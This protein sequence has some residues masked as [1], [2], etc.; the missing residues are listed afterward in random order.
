MK[1]F[2]LALLLALPLFANPQF[3]AL[4]QTVKAELAEHAIPGAV[5]AVV[6]GDKVVF[7]EAFGNVTT[8][9]RFRIGSLTKMFTAAAIVSLADEGKVALDVP[10]RTYVDD[11]PAPMGERTLDQ[12]L[13][14]RAGFVDR[15]DG[16]PL[17]SDD[18]FLDAERI[19]SYSSIGYSVA[20]RAA[21][22]ANDTTFDALLAQRV[23]TPLQMHA[24]SY[25]AD[26]S[27]DVAGYRLKRGRAVPASLLSHELLEPAGML[28]STADDLA[29]FAIAFMNG[30][31]APRVIAELSKPH[32]AIPGDTRHYGYG[33]FIDGDAVYHG[34]DEPTGSAFLKMIPNEKRAVIVLTNLAGRL[35]K[36]MAV[37]LHQP[38]PA[39]APQS[40]ALTASDI[41]DLIGEYDNAFGLRI[42]R[43]GNKALLGPPLPWFLRWLPLK[44]EL[45][46]LGADRYAIRVP[47]SVSA[48]P[49]PFL[50]VRDERG[51]VE[52]LFLRGRAFKRTR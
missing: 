3:D 22:A 16:A 11:L 19:L 9:G 5:V 45:V 26:P 38:P 4:R 34:G 30:G 20:G 33:T 46:K 35:E 43:K 52:L 8:D 49:I 28:Y 29:R 2:A 12:L 42:Q 27:R 17:K 40:S 51:K 7:V 21:A 24:T 10:V 41:A 31:L 44:R 32:A 47:R 50:V 14:H 39:P 13:K 25:A 37:A 18:V 6:E 15:V 36:S 1:R 48:D 23:F